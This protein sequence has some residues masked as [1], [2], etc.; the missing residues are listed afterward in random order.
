MEKNTSARKWCCIYF[1]LQRLSMLAL[2]FF[3]LR[4][5][6]SVFK[7]CK[8]MSDFFRDFWCVDVFCHV[9][10]CLYS[11]ARPI[12]TELCC[13]AAGQLS[14]TI[15][16]VTALW[17]QVVVNVYHKGINLWYISSDQ[18]VFCFLK[19]FMLAFSLIWVR[20][21]LHEA[22]PIGSLTLSARSRRPF[23][24][25]GYFPPSLLILFLVVPSQ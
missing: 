11:W 6:C 15:S 21:L 20:W 16:V 10:S 25:A 17:S 4:N 13:F 8:V 3:P 18:L 19:H 14:W 7:V 23:R 1:W 9:Q 5:M 24:Y 22:L 12:E 2:H